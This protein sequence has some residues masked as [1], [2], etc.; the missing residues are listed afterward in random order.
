MTAQTEGGVHDDW[1]VM[2]EGGGEQ[3]EDAFEE[4]RDVARPG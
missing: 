4:D 1:T 3:L 2:G